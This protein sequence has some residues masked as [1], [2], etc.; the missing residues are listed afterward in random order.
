MWLR[1]S[2]GLVDE[3]KWQTRVAQLA[4][5][6]EVREFLLRFGRVDRRAVHVAVARFDAQNCTQFLFKTRTFR[7]FR[8]F[9]A[10]I[11]IHFVVRRAIVVVV[12]VAEAPVAAK[13]LGSVAEL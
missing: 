2:V 13:Q 5:I 1:I 11:Q 6:E 8:V 10:Q 4:I 7:H 3:R 12:R 9:L